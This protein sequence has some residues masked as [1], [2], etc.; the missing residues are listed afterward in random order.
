MG[1]W[2]GDVSPDMTPVF[3]V[4]VDFAA[5]KDTMTVVAGTAHVRVAATDRVEARLI[6]EQMV[7]AVGRE[8]VDAAVD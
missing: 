3:D 8:P 5:D 7:A 4:Y 1:A 2:P 6:A